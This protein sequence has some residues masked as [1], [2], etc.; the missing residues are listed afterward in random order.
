M[1]IGWDMECNFKRCTISTQ[2]FIFQF[3]KSEQFC[4]VIC[5]VVQKPIKAPI[6][7]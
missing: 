7:L 4:T 2:Q 5:L 1:G 6:A 3:T